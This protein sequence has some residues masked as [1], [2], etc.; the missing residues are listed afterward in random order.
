MPDT[1]PFREVVL[2]DFEFVAAPGQPPEP[3][4]LVAELLRAGRTIRL[5]RDQFGPAP[6][7]PI[8]GDALF[9][10][11][12]A[13]AELGCHR[14]LG[15][16]MPARILDL[17]TEFRVRTNGLATP[18]GN[19]L[20]GTLAY[21][22]LD[23]MGATQKADMRFLIMGGGPWSACCPPC[24]RASTCRAPFCGAATWLRPPSWSTM[25][26]PSTLA[27]WRPCVSTGRASRTR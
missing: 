1:L 4:C 6:P 11:Y 12:Y 15:W 5:W 23:A 18:A 10:A 14:V 19:S 20:L 13:S 3:V 27:C 24:C 7:Y 8:D 26:S 21:F 17:F 16:P 22:G 2:V 25:A 9:V